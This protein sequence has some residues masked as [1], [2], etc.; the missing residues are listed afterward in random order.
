MYYFPCN[1]H[2]QLQRLNLAG[3]KGESCPTYTRCG[4]WC[5]ADAQQSLKRIAVKDSVP[6]I[7]PIH[8]LNAISLP[9][10]DVSICDLLL[11]ALSQG[12]WGEF[13][14]ESLQDHHSPLL[15]T[16]TFL[17]PTPKPSSWS[18]VPQ[19]SG[20]F[21]FGLLH[22]QLTLQPYLP[23]IRTLQMWAHTF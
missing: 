22:S 16:V 14:M 5:T 18:W 8:T 11:R 19:I 23:A 12:L 15:S 4:V 17:I 13:L 3:L 6:Y 21:C 2:G 1:Y 9:K 10:L 7:L 20:V